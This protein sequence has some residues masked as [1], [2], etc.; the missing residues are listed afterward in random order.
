MTLALLQGSLAVAVPLWQ[1]RVARWTSAHRATRAAEAVDVIASQG[2]II[3][4]RS[5]KRG[6]TAAA[7][8][9]LAEAIA[10]MSFQPGG[11]TVFE[12]HWDAALIG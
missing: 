6:E 8:N 11:L 7:F 1:E 4:Y 12:Q 2:D 5:Q 3:L 10:I 9:T